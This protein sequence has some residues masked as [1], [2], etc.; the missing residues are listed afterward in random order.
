MSLSKSL[1]VCGA[2]LAMG[3][4]VWAADSSGTK[5]D[6]PETPAR[7]G[8]ARLTKPWNELKDLTADEKAKILEIHQKALDEEKAIQKKE[9]ADILAVL[10]DDQKKEVAAIEVKE[11]SARAKKATSQPSGASAS[12]AK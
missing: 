8:H 3:T 2:A 7:T 10:T 1:W 4:M 9:H 5:S 11:R 12:S 6:A